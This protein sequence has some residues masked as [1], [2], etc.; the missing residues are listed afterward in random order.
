ML[1]AAWGNPPN[2]LDC[3]AARLF[4]PCGVGFLSRRKTKPGSVSPL[5][6]SKHATW[7]EVYMPEVNT[8]TGKGSVVLNCAECGVAFRTFP[9]RVGR[10][11]RCSR[12]CSDRAKTRLVGENSRAWAGGPV[13]KSCEVC[14]N[15]FKA[16]R[17][18]ASSARFC[19]HACKS[20][21]ISRRVTVP[22]GWC[23][24]AVVRR[25]CELEK[26][27]R[28]GASRAFCN[29]KCRS[30]KRAGEQAG[31]ANS[32]WRGGVTPETKR[33]R[34]SAETANWRTAVFQRD[35]YRCQHCGIRARVGLGHSVTLHA[36]HI[37]PFHTHHDLRFDVDNGLTLCAPCHHTVHRNVS[38][39]C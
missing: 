5:R 31:A 23:G 10:I 37:K 22:C 3:A 17:S 16:Q 11:T 21:G 38:R 7:S 20:V 29:R 24:A 4:L 39:I 30:L 18:R 25:P 26:A 1:S 8:I 32:Q 6:A 27:S 12:A 14:G 36:H 9:G 34:D 13:E 19:S 28:T 2:P 33:V 35:D 15:R